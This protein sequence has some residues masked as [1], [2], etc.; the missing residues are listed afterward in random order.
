MATAPPGWDL[1]RSFLAVLRLGSLSAAA[2]TLGLTQPTLGRHIAELESALGQPLFVRSQTGLSPTEAAQS[3]APS[4]E[5]MEAAAAAFLRTASGGLDD[6][7]GIVRVTA[8]E[9][10]GVEVL[11]PILTAF[12]ETHLAIDIELAKFRDAAI[13]SV[14]DYGPGVPDEALDRPLVRIIAGNGAQE[15]ISLLEHTSIGIKDWDHQPLAAK[16]AA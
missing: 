6:A 9:F 15:E 11:P 5:A 4:A 10:V 3:L 1:Y 14:R 7:K 2:R 8:S 16:L 12:R 13:V